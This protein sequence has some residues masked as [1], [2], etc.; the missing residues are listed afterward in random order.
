MD[1]VKVGIFAI[2]CVLLG[3]LGGIAARSVVAGIILAVFVFVGWVLWR[4]FK[5]QNSEVKE[6]TEE[7]EKKDI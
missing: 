3:I 1:L 2:G 7:V 4:L 6:P 5:M